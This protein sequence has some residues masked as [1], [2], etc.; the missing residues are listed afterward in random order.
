MLERWKLYIMYIGLLAALM[1]GLGCFGILISRNNKEEQKKAFWGLVGCHWYM[2]FICMALCLDGI[3]ASFEL[4]SGSLPPS[5][6]DF[7]FDVFCCILSLLCFIGLVYSIFLIK[8][9]ME[10]SK[11]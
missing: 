3:Y 11:K 4:F 1:F 8:E 10:N 9:Y 6:N 7:I 5:Q 2:P